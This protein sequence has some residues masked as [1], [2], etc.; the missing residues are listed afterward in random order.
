[1]FGESNLR[2]CWR[3]SKEHHLSQGAT[4]WQIST[5]IW[6]YYSSHS[7]I[8]CPED[9]TLHIN[10]QKFRPCR[11]RWRFGNM[12]SS[13]IV[14]SYIL[15]VCA[16]LEPE[17]VRAASTTLINGQNKNA[18]LR[19]Y[20]LRYSDLSST[21]EREEGRRAHVLLVA[22]VPRPSRC[23][24]CPSSS[25]IRWP[26]SLCVILSSSFFLLKIYTIIIYIAKRNTIII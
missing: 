15:F 18:T 6:S 23:A 14:S 13:S 11:D 20:L 4:G 25:G 16:W 12:Y 22:P 17:T 8:Y 10:L 9:D 24:L 21:R 1:M 19:T 26:P 5:H 2:S 3:C 7:H